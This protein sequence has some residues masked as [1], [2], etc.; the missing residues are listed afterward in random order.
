MFNFEQERHEMV[1]TGVDHSGADELY[2]PTCGRRIAVNWSPEFQKTVLE[3]GAELAIHT[4]GSGGLTMGAA[5]VSPQET[6]DTDELI[7]LEQWEHWLTE[8]NFAELWR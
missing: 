7:R 4:A 2:C 5:E 3:P 8:M 1:F 6:P